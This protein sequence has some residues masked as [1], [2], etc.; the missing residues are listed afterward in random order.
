MDLL[1]KIS[2]VIFAGIVGGRVA[3]R[4][5]LP[6]VSGYIIAGLLIGPS[7]LNIIASG[8][9][10]NFGIISEIALAAIAFSIG[11]EFLLKDMKETGK[12]IMIITLAEVFGAVTLVFL[13]CFF[14]FRQPFEFSIVVASMSA[15]TA[16]AGILMVIRELKARGPLVNTILPVVAI[17]DAIGIMVFSVALSIAKLTAGV[18][19][20]SWIELIWAPLSEILGSL[21]LGAVLGFLLSLL[22][23][24]AKGQSE[25]LC[26]VLAFILVGAGLSNQLGF[27]SLLTCMVMGAMVVNLLHN[28]NRIFNLLDDFTPPFNL[29]FFTFAGAGLDIAVFGKVG[30]LGLGY[31]LARATGKI[32]GATAGARLTKAEPQVT[33]YL[34]M[35]L[36]TQ[37]GISIGLSMVVARELPQYSESIITIILFSVLIYEIVG[38]I[39]AKIAII[40]AGEKNGAMKSIP[41]T[42]DN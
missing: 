33:K 42:E 20:F 7:F 15:A 4:F 34:G 6:N 24:K 35:S 8:E 17:D 21:L 5:K 16:P 2:I 31:I 3:N 41:Q 40:R 1:L 32:L 37:G 38:P 25:L 12:D 39:L 22:A 36:L 9:A 27:S 10:A 13:V 19:T 28:A 29:L 23:N 26:A 18:G 30:L 14:I 11:S